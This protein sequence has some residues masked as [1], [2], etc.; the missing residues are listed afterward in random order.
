M[1][2]ADFVSKDSDQT[3]TAP[4]GEQAPMVYPGKKNENSGRGIPFW[5]QQV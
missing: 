1:F 4:N 2:E 3:E 5:L